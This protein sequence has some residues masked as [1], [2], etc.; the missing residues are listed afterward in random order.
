MGLDS[1][2]L[3]KMLADVADGHIQLPDFQ[4]EWKW[5]DEHIASILATV[6]M[7]YPMG[8]VM[9][10]ET[11]GPGGRFKTR[12]LQGVQP[13]EDVQPEQLLLD[14]QQRMT[15]LY[16]ALKSGRPVDTVDQRDQPRALWYYIHIET[17]INPK[18]DRESAIRSVPESKVIRPL[19]R[20]AGL[21][22]STAEL[23]YEQGYFPLWLVFDSDGVEEW[24]WGYTQQDEER[25]R[26][27]LQF[28][29]A[30]LANVIG[31]AVPLIKLEKE[32]PRDAVCTVFEKVNTKG[33][34]LTVFELLTATFAGDGDY[35]ERYDEEFHLPDHWKETQGE[36]SAAYPALSGLQNTD[37]L[38]A[39][40][41]ASTYHEAGVPTSCKR[42]D[43]L[44]LELGDYLRWAP[45]ISDALHWA[46]D[47]LAEQC[48][49]RAEDLPYRTQLPPLAA[50]RTVLGR[51][52]DTPDARAKLARWYWCGVLGEQY[53]GTAD[54]RFPRDVEQVVT[55][56]RGGQEPDSI[57]EAR[58]VVRRLLSMNSR[59]S[60]AYKG[61][62][63]LL[64]QQECVDWYYADKPIAGDQVA[65]G[66]VDIHR[67]FPAAWCD[68]QKIDPARRDSVV[69][70]T[71]L[72]G[73]AAKT[74][75]KH[76]PAAG[77]EILE[78]ETGIRPQ[79]LDDALL[80]H[81]IEPE[82]LRASDFDTFFAR[83]TDVLVRMI[84]RAMGQRAVR[85]EAEESA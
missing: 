29:R 80:S 28:K 35:T 22:L 39:V 34:Q 66:T 69:N 2:P 63:A 72:S 45:A 10:L 76:A 71:L 46:G 24:Q 31:Y 16:Q 52:A 77:L 23:E 30:V 51:E 18:A 67:I 47:F 41:L 6:T 82:A 44:D 64:L 20:R 11:G 19:G 84:E 85:N 3:S 58:F 55:W 8:V 9:T 17:A 25:R 33:V 36:L 1:R 59:N 13:A 49:F 5:D 75:G 42:R 48:V 65:D 38:Q 70:K 79:W 81:A 73:R 40:C 7:D 50:I 26:L 83:R 32:T 12:P 74:L 27:W 43:M 15:S 37:F 57:Q 53:G 56:L 4:R 62:F 78:Q 60:A 61:V 21:D 54:S 68:K 14:G